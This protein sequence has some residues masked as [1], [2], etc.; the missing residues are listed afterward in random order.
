VPFF[1]LP[2]GQ[3]GIWW[4][5]TV[6]IGQPLG[7]WGT[8][9]MATTQLGAYQFLIGGQNATG[10][11]NIQAQC[12]LAQQTQTQSL[13]SVATALAYQQQFSPAFAFPMPSAA[14]RVRKIGTSPAIIHAGRRAVRRSIDLYLR[15]RPAEELRRF[16]AG[17]LVV[18]QGARLRYSVQRNGIS[19]MAQ[20]IHFGHGIPYVMHM[21]DPANDNDR[22]VASGC[23]YLNDTPL[24]DQLLAFILHVTDPDGERQL[25]ETTN[26]SPRLP[27][28]IAERLAA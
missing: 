16:V 21:L 26:W 20:A 12:W 10:S 22:R 24:L 18:I 19:I 23:V 11:S 13:T 17:D 28:H 6:T 4:P 2:D 5:E 1:S 15:M 8:N 3:L 14:Q 27:H 25:V 7:Y 9:A